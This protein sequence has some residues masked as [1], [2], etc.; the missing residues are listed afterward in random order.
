LPTGWLFSM[1]Y[2]RVQLPHSLFSRFISSS[3]DL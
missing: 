2:E 1:G 3:A